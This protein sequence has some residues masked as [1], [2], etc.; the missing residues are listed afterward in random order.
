MK[1]ADVHRCW[2]PA[3]GRWS[4]WAKPVLFAAL[5]DNAYPILRQVEARSLPPPPAWASALLLRG[6]ET[7]GGQQ[8]GDHYPYRAAEARD[9]ALVI[10][11]P[12]ASGA[13]LGVQFA[14]L[15]FRPVPLYNALA[16]PEAIVDVLPI[17]DVLVDGAERVAGA[18]AASPPAFLL[19]AD[20]RGGSR[21]LQVG[22]FDNRSVCR[23]ADFPSAQ[24][25]YDAGI[26]RAIV[27]CEVL[28]PD[29]EP[30]L[31]KWQERG[32]ALWRKRLDDDADASA[33]VA[34]ER[35]WGRRILERAR[36]ALLSRHPD[37][38]YGA[39]IEGASGG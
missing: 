1:R 25:L 10:D 18:P 31:L 2:A 12:G 7:R 28:A 16:A 13:V 6:A 36:E 15:G 35:W 39:I 26:R 19:D 24:A 8:V 27:I 32:I 3:D 11:L 30:V 29:L 23:P 9:T 33:F 20:R 38:S 5:E 17:I 34:R 22:A 4:R 21:S 14:E 37:G